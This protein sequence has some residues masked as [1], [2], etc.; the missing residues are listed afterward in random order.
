MILA[1]NWTE[2]F[3]G[4]EDWEFLLE[5]A[6]RT[7]AMYVIIL[8]GLRLLGKRGV[9]QLSI[10][11]LVVIISLGSAAGD[12]MFY[13]EVGLAV[14]V[15]IFAVIVLS[16]R[17][18]TYLTA[19]SQTVD[20]IIE[21]KCAYLIEDGEFS[22]DNFSKETLAHDEFFSELR[23]YSISHLGQVKTAILETS[24]SISVYYFEDDE[25]KYGLPIL[26]RLFD[27]GCCEIL[28]RAHYACCFCGNVVL[29]APTEKNECKKCAHDK[30]VKAI[31]DLRVK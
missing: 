31:S 8:T 25:V 21:G 13:K 1:I 16:Y 7:F 20:D 3:I 24:G 18:T 23:Q 11:E 10:F 6:L 26:P 5:I 15:I 12:P 17:L 30:W 9:K 4:K 19:K 2:F 29:L 27:A 14:P 22:V 28:E